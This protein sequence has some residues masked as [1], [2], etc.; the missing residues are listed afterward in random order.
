[1]KMEQI[2]G[3]E[4]SAINL[5]RQGIAQNKTYYI[6]YKAKTL[7]QEYITSM[8]RKLQHTFVYL[9]NFASRKS[10]SLHPSNS[11]F[12][13]AITTLHPVYYN[14]IIASTPGPPSE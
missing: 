13:A 5:W 6:Q 3:T 2:E 7:N 14:S 1:M 4:T 12:A 11:Y 10:N 8:W 9:G